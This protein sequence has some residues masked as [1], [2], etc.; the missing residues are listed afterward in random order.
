MKNIND[1][2][3]M[4]LPMLMLVPPPK[5]LDEQMISNLA[6]FG[7]AV[8]LCVK[9]RVSGLTQ[10]QIAKYLGFSN[11]HFTKVLQSKAYLSS[12]Q[13][14]ILER[15]CSNKAISQYQ[16][17]VNATVAEAVET[18]DQKIARLQEELRLARAA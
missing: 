18:P 5:R 7:E 15:L 4:S 17:R 1:L 16:E 14:S 10:A 9:E 2:L 3:Q 11:P 8:R 13:I 12:D 6:N